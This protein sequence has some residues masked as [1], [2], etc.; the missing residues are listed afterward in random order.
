MFIVYE[1]NSFF[2]CVLSSWSSKKTIYWFIN[3]VLC[4]RNDLHF[5][6]YIYCL[7]RHSWSFK[8]DENVSS[9]LQLVANVFESTIKGNLIIR[10]NCCQT[11]HIRNC[12]LKRIL[13]LTWAK[14]GYQY[15]V[16]VECK[17]HW[18]F[19]FS[20]PLTLSPWEETV[21]NS[22]DIE[23]SQEETAD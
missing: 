11:N 20:K 5:W 4:L 9:F 10:W 23:K 6:Q 12:S 17:R 21:S 14:R 7:L 19:E 18:R 1:P 8:M 16:C 3:S 13:I 2:V 22:N 15:N